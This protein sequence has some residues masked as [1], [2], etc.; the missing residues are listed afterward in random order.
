M[1][2]LWGGSCTLLGEGQG[3]GAPQLSLLLGRRRR[4]WRPSFGAAGA[5]P[6]APQAP[7][8]WRRRRPSFDAAGARRRAPQA[9]GNLRGEKKP[10][11]NQTILLFTLNLKT[12]FLAS[13]SFSEPR[14]DRLKLLSV[15]CSYS[16]D[17]P[18]SS[19]R[20]PTAEV[21]STGAGASNE[22]RSY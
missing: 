16:I 15:Y 12:H 18:I 9:S 2:S 22:V 7:L 10:F 13:E 5:P 17:I 21:G 20:L 6:T 4:P 8:L 14:Y 19:E 3:G 1:K 11:F